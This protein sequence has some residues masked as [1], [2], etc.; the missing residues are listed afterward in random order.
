[1][2]RILNILLFVV[3]PVF[4]ISAQTEVSISTEKVVIDGQKF[5]LHTVESGQTLFSICKAY[6]VTEEE[7]ILS[8]PEIQNK[9]LKLGQVVK[10]KINDEVSSDGKHIVYTVKPG[11]TLYSLCRKYGITEEE[12]YLIN[13]DVKKNKAL[14]IGQEIKFPVK[15]IEDKIPDAI[16]DTVNF[17][18]H[19]IDKGET[20]Y[21]LT[22]KYNVTKEELIA[23]NPDFDGISL[24]VGDVLKIP[25]KALIISNDQQNFVDSLGNVNYNAPDTVVKEVNYCEEKDWF[26]HGKNFEI[27][28]LLPFETG[29]NMRNLYNQATANRD[30]RLYLVTE[31]MISF[32]SG[33][34]MAFEKFKTYDTKINVKVYDIGKDNTAIASLIENNKLSESD[35]I[36]GPAFKSQ[37]EYLNTNL[38][39]DKAVILLPFVDDAVILEKYSRN[40]MLR[41]STI[42]VV[43]AIAEFALLNPTGNFLIIEGTTEE[44]KTIASQYKNALVAKLGSENH[45]RLV[46]FGGKDLAGIKSMVIKGVDN[47]VIMPFSTE[48]SA[49]NIFLDLFP[50][51]EYDIT[52]ISDPAV[53]EY[54]TIDPTY[55]SR[56][57]FSYYTGVNVDYSDAVTK[58][59][60]SE[61]RD[62]FLCEPD[63]FTFMAY[64][65]MSFF[66]LR[67]LRYGNN[68]PVC[69]SAG[70]EFDGVAGH[71]EYTSKP[72]FS[73]NSYSNNSV[74]IFTLQED[75]SFKQVF[76]LVKE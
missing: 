65:A 44:Q 20:V 30:Q 69:I 34:L 63:D 38:N 10:I 43:D 57:K 68:F 9:T 73:E 32:Y 24:K 70:N 31:K 54:E 21:G 8:N 19:L 22:K 39:N 62:I 28:M 25:K 66:I 48:T 71:Q 11:D 6:K 42:M 59:L 52:L 47:F 56:I 36:I 49:T 3:I 74:Y 72:N 64:D 5:Y 45:V 1:M 27:V 23:A 16:K 26:T 53:L 7:I 50:L 15:V 76:P 51:K 61:Y 12:F 17:V 18:Y 4:Y 60:L 33:C 37:V 2:K 35:V 29:A 75:Y 13:T 41:P 14:K 58:K 55:Y 40:I 46:S 67:L